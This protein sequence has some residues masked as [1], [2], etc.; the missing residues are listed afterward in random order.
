MKRTLIML[1][2]LI[3]LAPNALAY[4]IESDCYDKESPLTKKRDYRYHNGFGGTQEII[5]YRY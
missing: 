1:T 2:I 4:C 5:Y 3:L